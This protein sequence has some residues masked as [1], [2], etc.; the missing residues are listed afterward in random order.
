VDVA[1][2]GVYNFEFVHPRCVQDNKRC[3]FFNQTQQLIEKFAPFIILYTAGMNKLKKLLTY[4]F[5][6]LLTPQSSVYLDKLDGF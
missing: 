3:E 6:S 1:L 2:I 4:L 5:T